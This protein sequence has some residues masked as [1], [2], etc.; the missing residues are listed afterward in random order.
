[1]DFDSCLRYNGPEENSV[2]CTY[3]FSGFEA[4]VFEHEISMIRMKCWKFSSYTQCGYNTTSDYGFLLDGQAS[5]MLS[6]R[7]DRS[8]YCGKVLAYVD[9]MDITVVYEGE[10]ET[11]NLSWGSTKSAYR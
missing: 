8:D 5:L 1:L 6:S 10:V 9:S 3:G 2:F 11:E 4:D 7:W